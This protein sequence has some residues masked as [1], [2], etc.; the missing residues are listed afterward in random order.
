MIS[1]FDFNRN[2]NNAVMA[3]GNSTHDYET[4]DA[5]EGNFVKNI[6]K[7]S[8]PTQTEQS[9]VGTPQSSSR[10]DISQEE[11]TTRP[12][13]EKRSRLNAP[14]A[15]IREVQKQYEAVNEPEN[16][17]KCYLSGKR[18]AMKLK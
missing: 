3:Q 13:E 10:K 1:H 6:R 16:D 17:E 5:G 14:N 4:K 7:I 12:V 2:N 18:V 15:A 8:T 9:F 11:E